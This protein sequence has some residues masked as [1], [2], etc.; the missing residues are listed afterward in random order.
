METRLEPSCGIRNCVM[1]AT[2]SPRVIHPQ[3]ML[4]YHADVLG[5]QLPGGRY[6]CGYWRQEYE[7]LAIWVTV[8]AGDPWLR[9]RWEDGHETVH[10]TRWD[11]RVDRVLDEP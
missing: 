6:L 7:V 4:A 5:P 11:A 2:R 9:V 8:S 10:C 3:A 1:H